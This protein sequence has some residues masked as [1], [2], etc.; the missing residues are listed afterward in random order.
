MIRELRRIISYLEETDL[1]SSLTETLSAEVKS[2]LSDDGV[3][4][5]ANAAM[6]VRGRGLN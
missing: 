6:I 5:A 3:S 2:V 4:I 1:G